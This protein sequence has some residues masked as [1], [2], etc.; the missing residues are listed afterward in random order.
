MRDFNYSETREQR[1]EYLLYQTRF[2]RI[3]KWNTNRRSS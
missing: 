1:K 2:V 3:K